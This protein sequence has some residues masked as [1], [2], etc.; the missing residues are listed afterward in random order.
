MLADGGGGG[1]DDLLN[2]SG[3]L[4]LAE[5]LC[6][7]TNGLSAPSVAVGATVV[8]VVAVVVVA[9]LN[10]KDA[11]VAPIE[12]DA[13]LSIELLVLSLLCTMGDAFS[14]L[15][16]GGGGAVDV[17]KGG[18]GEAL[19]AAAAD[20]AAGGMI[21]G[22]IKRAAS[23]PLLCAR[24]AAVS[25]CWIMSIVSRSRRVMGGTGLLSQQYIIVLNVSCS[26]L[27]SKLTFS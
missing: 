8:V 2:T 17:V 18:F 13:A 14:G 5:R 19:A 26:S 4:V 10:R 9:A 1:V 16:G 22:L 11:K 24:M 20:L 23:T 25:A 27:T 7:G 3:E 12:A 6:P 15:A 21:E